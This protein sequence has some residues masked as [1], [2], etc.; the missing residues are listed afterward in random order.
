MANELRS[1]T[2]IEIFKLWG[3][4]DVT[5]DLDSDVNILSGTNGGGKSTLLSCAYH[6][7]KLGFIPKDVA[8]VDKAKVTFNNGKFVFFERVFIK[9]TISSLKLK[10][11][12]SDRFKK[13]LADIKDEAG[14]KFNKVK[15]V[16]AEMS[17]SSFD[18]DN[19]HPNEVTESELDSLKT[20]AISTF[21]ATIVDSE[22][23]K[24]IS[25]E[26]IRTEL[27]LKIFK[28]QKEYLDYQ[29]NI[30]KRKDL[31]VQTSDDIK[32]DIEILNKPYNL[33]LNLIDNYFSK[34]EKKVDR[35]KE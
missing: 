27:D 7:I 5:W 14:K 8:V 34:T 26:N 3:E 15:S 13:I 18:N 12:K 31:I 19:N 29:L 24:K 22:A 1:I 2:K 25:D 33:F 35:K 9:E 28:L 11:K 20:S 21:D 6:L 23:I 30:S 17:F 10:A 16:E 4:Y 32:N